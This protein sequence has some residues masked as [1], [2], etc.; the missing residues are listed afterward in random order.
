MAARFFLRSELRKAQ[1]PFIGP[2]GG[3]WADAAHTIPWK[4]PGAAGG[5]A[6]N[7]LVAQGDKLI[8]ELSHYLSGKGKGISPQDYDNLD[9]VVGQLRD[10]RDQLKTATDKAHQKM[11]STGDQD[12][13]EHA[14]HLAHAL[15]RVETALGIKKPS[16]SSVPKADVPKPKAA[17]Q[18]PIG[19]ANEHNID[20]V[21]A[22]MARAWHQRWKNGITPEPISGTLHKQI[23]NYLVRH[24]DRGMNAEDHMAAAKFH[25]QYGDDVYSGEKLPSL[26]HKLARSQRRHLHST[27]ANLHEKMATNPDFVGKVYAIAGKKPKVKKSFSGLD[28]I[29]EYANNSRFEEVEMGQ[30][31]LK[32]GFP[33]PVASS[34]AA[35][36]MAGGAAQG[37]SS[38]RRWKGPAG[39]WLYEHDNPDHKA[40]IDA[41]NAAETNPGTAGDLIN[42]HQAAAAAHLKAAQSMHQDPQAAAEHAQVA[43]DHAKAAAVVHANYFTGKDAAGAS[44]QPG[45]AP[46]AS[47]PGQQPG[48]APAQPPMPGKSIAPGQTPVPPTDMKTTPSNPGGGQPPI[49]PSQPGGA[50][51]PAK[52]Q[53]EKM[54][55]FQKSIDGIDGLS[56]YLAKAQGMPEGGP[57]EQLGTGE[58]QGG[59]VDGVGQQSGDGD[60]GGKGSG[61]PGVAHE[62]LSEDDEEDEGQMKPHKKPIE[63]AK[64]MAVPAHQRE[65]VAREHAVAVS[66]LQKSDDV[67][68]G[69]GVGRKLPLSAPVPRAISW[70]QGKD[71]FVTYSNQSDL[72]VERLTK[73]GEFYVGDAPQISRVA[74]LVAQQ[75][76]CPSCQSRMAKSL[77]VCP[78]CGEGAQ[79]A[80]PRVISDGES[81]PKSEYNR[82]GL[83]RPARHRGDIYFPGK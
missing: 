31:F 78:E 63:T 40:A 45:Q 5:G 73:S 19:K 20:A 14:N 18:A 28:G 50:I 15:H 36:A 38:I 35:P 4:E 67:V 58:E 79:R 37:G 66:Q 55:K 59:K 53:A 70:R 16:A 69:L 62:K 23:A 48:T 65:M 72:D 12:D 6:G 47:A 22:G 76:Q 68:V 17:K 52:S 41:S 7:A 80:V 49:A 24:H 42:A 30:D 71:G 21:P 57:Q 10:T 27:L 61:A 29:Q 1:G 82:P 44:A 46:V 32:K 51:P 75:V 39:K 83:L 81:A 2:K 43:A 64:S 25:E 77:A 8:S 13:A 26:P 33:P 56:A 3:K 34:P 60:S 54:K 9:T 74:P 11:Q